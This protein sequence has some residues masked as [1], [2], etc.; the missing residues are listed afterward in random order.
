MTHA[1]SGPFLTRRVL[2]AGLIAAV[3][4]K[5]NGA[6]A[7]NQSDVIIIGAGLAGLQAAIILQD[8][9]V[10]FRVIEASQRVGGRVVTLDDVEGRPEGGG[11]EVGVMY[12]RVMSMLDRLHIPLRAR[13]GEANKYV[14]NLGG[15]FI[16]AKDW[17]TAPQNKLTGDL[18]NRLPFE[19][20]NYFMSKPNP[21]GTDLE[22]WLEPQYAKYDISLAQYLRGLGAD[23]EALR[24]ILLTQVVD[25]LDDLSALWMLR[26]DAG[27]DFSRAGGGG[28]SRLQFV[29]GGMSRLPEAMAAALK[30]EIEF[31][32]FATGIRASKRGVEVECE[33]GAI[34][35]AKVVIC[36]TPLP[37]ARKLKFDP[38]LPRLHAEAIAETPFGQATSVYLPIKEKYWEV[39]GLP[40][41]M[42]TDSTKIGRVMKWTTEVGDYLWLYLSGASNVAYRNMGDDDVMQIVLDEL[43]RQRPAMQGR[44]GKGK[45]MNWSR[46]RFTGGTFARVAPGQVKKFG[47]VLSKPAHQR[48]HFAGEHTAQ[49]FA[50]LEGAMES[51]ERAAINALNSL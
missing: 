7:A 47:D 42:W 28:G 51:G 39:D 35:R 36:A 5:T 34:Y 38:G 40:A 2:T 24:L 11:S 48:I 29:V 15:T 43:Y 44:L 17:P 1:Q 10:N 20:E 13:L 8:Q 26:R 49:L 25:S 22:A 37:I 18:R 31:G 27:R 32:H 12:A 3:T 6:A 45:V 50:G 30:T 14:L 16:A 21:L 23:D 41:A 4:A 19:L 9:G 33:D 46:N